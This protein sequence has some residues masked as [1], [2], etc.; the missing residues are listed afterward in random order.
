MNRFEMAMI[1]Q[2]KVSE[3][4]CLVASKS[5]NK[6]P[7]YYKTLKEL[8]LWCIIQSLLSI[9]GDEDVTLNDTIM[10][11]FEECSAGIKRAV[12]IEVHEGD[13]T[14]QLLEKYDGVKDVYKKI[15]KAC[16]DAGLKIEG[17]TIV[18]A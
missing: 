5:G 18:K 9:P 10:K 1:A 4:D 17:S 14:L 8:K 12:V 6:N 2:N 13:D 15:K 3:L 16:E 7:D 11:Y